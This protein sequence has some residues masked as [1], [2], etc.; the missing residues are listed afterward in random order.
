VVTGDWWNMVR[1][2][3]L[4]KTMWVTSLE[5]SGSSIMVY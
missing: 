3:N 5:G 2:G 1:A 4:L